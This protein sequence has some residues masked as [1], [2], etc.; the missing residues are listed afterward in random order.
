MARTPGIAFAS[1]SGI[2]TEVTGRPLAMA[3]LTYTSVAR[4]W[5]GLIAD[6]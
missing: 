2:T 3:S 1:A 6:L 4:S 5:E